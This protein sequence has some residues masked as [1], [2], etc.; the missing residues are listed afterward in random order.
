MSEILMTNVCVDCGEE[1]PLSEYYLDQN[2]GNVYDGEHR[3]GWRE[4]VIRGV[5]RVVRHKWLGN[6][7]FLSRRNGLVG[8]PVSHPWHNNKYV[9]RMRHSAHGGVCSS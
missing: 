5:C 9:P 8:F 3:R 4:W 1:K 6:A 2:G 7:D